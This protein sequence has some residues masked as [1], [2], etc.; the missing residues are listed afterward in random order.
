MPDPIRKHSGYGHLWPLRPACS[1]NPFQLRFSKEGMDHTVQNRPG[2]DLGG[3]IRVW[4]NTSGLKASRCAGIIRP[5]FWQDATIP[6]PVSHFQTVFRSSTNVLG[7][8]VQIH[9]GSDLFMANCVRF[10]PNGSGPESWQC[11]RITRP[12]SGHCLPADADPMR[13]GSGMFTGGLR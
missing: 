12:A 6:L 8:I 9:P 11:A 1:Q 4:T 2:S 13:I 3:L 7:K 5:G 10:W